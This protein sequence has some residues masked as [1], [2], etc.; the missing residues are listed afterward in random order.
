MKQK[1]KFICG[2]ENKGILTFDCKDCFDKS[3]YE[4]EEQERHIQNFLKQERQKTLSKIK[5]KLLYSRGYG[6]YCL[7]CRKEIIKILKEVEK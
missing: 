7:P 1:I 6:Y 4:A 3:L 5:K 2:C